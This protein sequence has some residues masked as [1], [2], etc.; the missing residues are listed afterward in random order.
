MI[1]PRLAHAISIAAYAH[2]NQMRKATSI[3][4][5]LSPVFGDGDSPKLYVR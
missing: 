3:P 4:L 1:S 5:Y 2:R